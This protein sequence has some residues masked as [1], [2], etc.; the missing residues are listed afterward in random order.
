VQSDQL[1]YP[2]DTHHPKGHVELDHLEH[3]EQ[4]QGAV[5]IVCGGHLLGGIRRPIMYNVRHKY[6]RK[7]IIISIERG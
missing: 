2:L 6:G 4:V 5:F 7:P 3:L 1:K